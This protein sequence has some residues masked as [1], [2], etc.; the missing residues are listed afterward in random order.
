MTDV[1]YIGGMPRELQG[2]LFQIFSEAQ[3]VLREDLV[4]T[5][6]VFLLIT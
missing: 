3:Q 6:W 5:S 1:S 4:T 2:A